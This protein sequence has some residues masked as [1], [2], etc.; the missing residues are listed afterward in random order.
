MEALAVI[1]PYGRGEQIYAQQ[2]PAEYWYRLVSGA[3]KKYV[4][5]A[6]GRRRALD[7]LLPG[8]FVGFTTGER[9]VSGVQAI[10]D[11]TVAAGYPRRYV[12]LL[13]NSDLRVRQY[14]RQRAFEAVFRSE[15]WWLILE[16]P[17]TLEKVRSFPVQVQQHVLDCGGNALTPLLSQH[18]IAD[19]LGLSVAEVS[20]AL[21]DLKGDN[22]MRIASMCHVTIVDRDACDEESG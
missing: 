12:E 2:E 13:A 3:A 11:G 6:D 5:V 21:N 4:V 17:T 7:V 8:D 20:R 16:Q 15:I 14:I 22:E 10:V 9:H 19:C 18:D 1:A